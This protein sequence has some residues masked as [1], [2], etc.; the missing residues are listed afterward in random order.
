MTHHLLKIGAICE[1]CG[2]LLPQQGQLKRWL[3]GLRAVHCAA[4]GFG[5]GD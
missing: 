5:V 3:G 1:I 4:V 2:F